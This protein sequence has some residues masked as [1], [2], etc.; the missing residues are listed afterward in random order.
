MVR[1][2]IEA[3]AEGLRKRTNTAALTFL[4]SY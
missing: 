4:E 1:E 2:N 3:A